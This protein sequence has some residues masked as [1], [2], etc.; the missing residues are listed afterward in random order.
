VP[1]WDAAR[2]VLDDTMRAV[3]GGQSPTAALEQAEAK[4]NP[5]LK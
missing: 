4:V 3:A 2:H 1:G 5:L